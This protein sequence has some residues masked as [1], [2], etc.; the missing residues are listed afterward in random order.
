MC[1]ACVCVPFSLLHTLVTPLALRK[2][3]KNLMCSKAAAKHHPLSLSLT[4]AVHVDEIPV[5]FFL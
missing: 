3:K 2:K 5:H 4:W 1:R